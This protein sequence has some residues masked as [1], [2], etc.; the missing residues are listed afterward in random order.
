MGIR[1]T[2]NDD[3]DV[4]AFAVIDEIYQLLCM[5]LTVGKSMVAETRSQVLN[6]VS[7]KYEI[8]G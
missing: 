6:F 7:G 2:T 8:E 4:V 3:L 5:S 1:V